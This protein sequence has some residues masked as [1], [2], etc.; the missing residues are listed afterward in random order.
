MAYDRKYRRRAIDYLAEGHTFRATAALFR[1]STT[2]LQKWKSQLKES[3]DLTPKKR[4][5]T[6]RKIDPEQLRTHIETHPDAY[7]KEI[8]KAF[9]CSIS[10]VEKALKRLKISRKKN[11]DIPREM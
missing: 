9:G 4:K 2:T 7:L 8:A 10:A 1:I 3:G 5:R 11:A 6:W